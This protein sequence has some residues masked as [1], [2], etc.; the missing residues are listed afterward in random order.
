MRYPPAKK[1]KLDSPWLG[2]Y[3]VV[4]LAGWAVGVQ[5]PPD[6]QIL[7]IHCQDLKKIPHPR[8]LVS[9]LQSDQPDPSAARMVIDA[10]MVCQSMPGST[11]STVSGMP[12]QQ[13]LLQ[14]PDTGVTVLPPKGS[15]C[16]DSSHGLHPFFWNR[17]DAGPVRLASFVHAF[18][19]RVAVL[20]DYWHY[21]LA[22]PEGRNVGFWRM[23]PYL[24]FVPAHAQA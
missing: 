10:S 1:C 20:Q 11:S 24:F 15:I 16:I 17:F 14:A 19:Y 13:S 9:W 12:S 5:L 7:M 6:S 3:L 23:F 4:S 8:G 22:V 18:N 21:E 2:P